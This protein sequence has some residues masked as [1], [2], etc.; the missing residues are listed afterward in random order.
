[1]SRKDT[2]RLGDIVAAVDAI[3][4]HLTRGGLDDG[5]VYDAVRV[6]LIEIG[7]AVEGIDPSVL[8]DVARVPWKEIARMRDHLAHRYFDTDHAIVQ[9]VVDNDLDALAGAV[10]LLIDRIDADD[11]SGSS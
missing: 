3:R 2:A 4:G 5:L 9:D 11:A 10:Q 1:L 6:R 8:D 7:E